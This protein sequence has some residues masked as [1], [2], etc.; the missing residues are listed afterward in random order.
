MKIRKITK[1]AQNVSVQDVVNDYNDK[2]M[3]IV[4]DFQRRVVWQRDTANKYIESVS[5]GTAV[6]GIIVAASLGVRRR[7]RSSKRRN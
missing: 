6:S 3:A 4:K 1:T 7:R 2:K 5:K